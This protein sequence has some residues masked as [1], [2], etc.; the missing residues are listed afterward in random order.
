MAWMTAEW[1]RTQLKGGVVQQAFDTEDGDGARE[2]C[3]MAG[4]KK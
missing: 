2:S 4:R 3:E 1:E